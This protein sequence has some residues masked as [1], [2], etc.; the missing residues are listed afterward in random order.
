MAPEVVISPQTYFST[1]SSQRGQPK[2]SKN[3]PKPLPF[4]FLEPV[5]GGDG[6][7]TCAQRTWLVGKQ[8]GLKPRGLEAL[9]IKGLEAQ[10]RI[11]HPHLS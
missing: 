1:K 3:K 5:Q 11:N 8:L 6:V 7:T 10:I 9:M 2:G 4:D